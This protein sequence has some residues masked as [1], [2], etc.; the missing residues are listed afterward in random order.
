MEKKKKEGREGKNKGRY[1]WIATDASTL[2]G[3]REDITTKRSFRRII[4]EWDGYAGLYH[5][6]LLLWPAD[7]TVSS[8]A[9]WN[10]ILPSI[11]EM[12]RGRGEW[13]Y[14]AGSK[15]WP[16]VNFVEISRRAEDVFSRG[17]GS[18]RLGKLNDTRGVVA[19]DDENPVAGCYS[20]YKVWINPRPT[21][22]SATMIG[23]DRIVLSFLSLAP[24][25]F[26]SVSMER[27]RGIWRQ[28]RK[29]FP[30]FS[31]CNCILLDVKYN[32]TCV[33]F[34]RLPLL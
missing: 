24:C 17:G 18:F 8:W 4:R 6:R 12:W 21:R 16:R 31:F 14:R 1:G 34:A 20:G 5:G 11:P 15:L 9:S 30:I 13:T 3:T 27:R 28:L 22:L 29:K 26:S 7:I 25:R 2:V 19:R 32:Q 33:S 23:R 10:R